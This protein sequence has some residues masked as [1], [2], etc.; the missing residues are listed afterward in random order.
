MEMI[1]SNKNEK[2]KNIQA[3]L[4]LKKERDR[5]GVFVIEGLR[6]FKDTLE[7]A[8]EYIEAVFVSES[9]FATDAMQ[10]IKENILKPGIT[11]Y[12]IS[13][14]ITVAKDSVFESISQTVTPQGIM[15][16]VR[17]PEYNLKKIM[18]TNIISGCSEISDGYHI[19]KG[20]CQRKKLL[21]LENIQDPGNL[22]TML[23]TAEAAGISGIIMSRD[24][25]DIFSPKVVRSTMGSI[26]RMP[27]Y[28][29]E[30]FYSA[31][32]TLKADAVTVYAAYLHGGIPYTEVTY[33][34]KIA[35]MIGNEGNG[36][37]EEAVTKADKRIYIPMAGKIESLNA[38]VAA[39]ILMYN[40][41]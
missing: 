18:S 28:Y 27:F 33:T 11:Q 14:K 32:E 41:R 21:L 6:I 16:I 38:A 24:C 35:I 39:A 22:G 34:E 12:K 7:T 23:R 8:P 17:K 10:E 1:T 31:I 15:S 30:D 40:L 3:L 29:A 4:K 26:F 13:D 20:T 2:I 36:L 37:S 19:E 9:F 25:A 5:Q